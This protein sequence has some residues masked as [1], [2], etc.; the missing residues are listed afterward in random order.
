MRRVSGSTRVKANTFCTSLQRKILQKLLICPENKVAL[1]V[2]IWLPSPR[3]PVRT[4]SSEIWCISF[5]KI[6]FNLNFPFSLP[7]WNFWSIMAHGS[8]FTSW[9]ILCPDTVIPID[10]VIWCFVP[11]CVLW[12]KKEKRVSCRDIW[13]LMKIKKRISFREIKTNSMNTFFLPVACSIAGALTEM[14]ATS[15]ISAAYIIQIGYLC[16]GRRQIYFEWIIAFPSF[17]SWM[18]IIIIILAILIS[19]SNSNT[20]FLEGTFD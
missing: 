20:I 8:T 2:M 6:C 16:S 3:R 18:I 19:I 7:L 9:T 10:N 12:G 1:D 5:W 11:A 13:N 17:D 15:A 14:T 4:Q